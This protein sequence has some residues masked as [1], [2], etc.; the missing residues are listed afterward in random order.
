LFPLLPA[1]E[2]FDGDHEKVKL[3]NKLVCE[4]MGFTSWAPVSGQTYSRKLDYKVL[5]CLSGVAQS[6]YKM[7]SDIRLLASMKE[8]GKDALL[9]RLCCIVGV[10]ASVF[11]L[12]QRSRS[13]RARSGRARWRTSATRCAPSVSA[14]W[15]AT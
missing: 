14:A 7:C 2:L 4:K 8:I 1:A 9:V 12:L 13:E 6:A 15:R 10:M 3:L 11:V 5:S